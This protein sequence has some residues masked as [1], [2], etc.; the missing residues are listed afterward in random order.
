[1]INKKEIDKRIRLEESIEEMLHI[2]KYNREKVEE[3]KSVLF[4]KGIMKGQVQKIINGVKKLNQLNEKMLIILAYALNDCTGKNEVN[5]INFYSKEEIESFLEKDLELNEL[6]DKVKFPFT[7]ENVSKVDESYVST[8]ML[9][10]VE[11]LYNSNVLIYNYR[12]GSYKFKKNIA[13]EL[14]KSII[15]NQN[16]INDKVNE[17]M[18]T[19]KLDEPIY[20]NVLN[21]SGKEIDY[22]INVNQLTIYQSELVIAQGFHSINALMEVAKINPE[23]NISVDLSISHLDEH[24]MRHLINKLKL[25]GGAS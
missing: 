21:K 6:A 23:L 1:M 25:K 10:F 14:N 22:N 19:G 16:L 13:G 2:I 9:H 18:K 11:K 8:V 15:L 7:I 12:Q 17:V 20:I 5:P 4:T 24:K 3:L